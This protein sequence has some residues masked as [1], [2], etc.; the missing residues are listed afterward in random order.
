MEVNKQQV[1]WTV[2]LLTT[3]R[4]VHGHS[5]DLEVRIVLQIQYKY[6]DNTLNIFNPKS[7]ANNFA[8]IGTKKFYMRLNF[9][10]CSFIWLR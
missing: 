2:I 10:V 3:N 5:V 7:I 6:V 1:L 4:I 8:C 9:N